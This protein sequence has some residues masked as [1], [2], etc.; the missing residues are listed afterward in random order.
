MKNF[1]VVLLGFILLIFGNFKS[2]DTIPPLN[3]EV[4]KYVKSVIGQQVDRGE[5]WDLAAAALSYAGAYLDRSSQ[6]TIY[7]F[8]KKLNPDKDE[9]FPGDI[10]QF[11]NIQLEYQK[12]NAIYTESM[13]HHTSIIYEVLEKGHYKLAHQN[14]AYTGKKVGISEFKLANVKK[15]KM[16]FYRPVPN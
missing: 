6:K 10:I 14:T 8:G 15:G 4:V 7:I 16:I 5:C 2:P 11:E 9:I 1:S 12:G 3:K 13:A